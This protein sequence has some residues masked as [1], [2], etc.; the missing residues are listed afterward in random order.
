MTTFGTVAPQVERGPSGKPLIIPPG[1]GEPVEYE[2]AS[3]YG[4]AIDNGAGLL[5]W[6]K[7]MVL[8][9][10]ASTG[11]P[12]LIKAARPL[13]YDV[14]KKKLHELA[15]SAMTLAGSGNKRDEGSALHSYTELIDKGLPLP[16][17]LEP[18]VLA[19]L[20]AYR[21]ITAGLTYPAIEGFVVVDEVQV[22]GSFDRLIKVPDAEP[23]PAWLRGRT[24]IG[25]LKTGN[26]EAAIAGIGVQLA[27]YSR[28]KTYD[29]ATGA[30]GELNVDQNIGLVVHLPLSSGKAQ[31]IAVDLSLGWQGVLAAQAA[32][33]YQAAARLACKS[34]DQG[35]GFY[36]NGNPCRSCKGVRRV[37][38]GVTVVAA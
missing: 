18:E 28:G 26:A 36:K 34:C 14:D 2:R 6:A 27:L 7:C 20:D 25:D 35:S 22:A 13:E 8:K 29:P 32:R 10:A 38:I 19:D 3:S 33:A 12:S 24:V 31:I 37:P 15:E 11:G 30:R 1:G 17:G 16:D 4:K 5:Y 21:R 23:W 9:G